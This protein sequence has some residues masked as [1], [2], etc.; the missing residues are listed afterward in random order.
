M[1]AAVASAFAATV[2]EP[3]LASLGGGGYLLVHTPQEDLVH[4]FFVD[5]PGIG[6]RTDAPIPTME[7][8]I[9]GFSGADQAFHAG[10]GSLAV[11]GTLDGLVQAHDRHGQLPLTAVVAPARALAADGFELEP[12]QATVLR[13]LSRILSLTPES[14]Q[15]YLPEDRPPQAG[16]TLANPALAE[17]LDGIGAGEVRRF[18]DLPGVDDL[19]EDVAAAGGALTA[20]DLAN[21]SPIERQSLVV[22]HCGARLVTNPSPALGGRILAV[23][24]Q[25]LNL[26]GPAAQ[27][28][29]G[30]ARVV[31][32]LRVATEREKTALANGIPIATKGTTHVSVA[33]ADGM[34]ASLTQ[35]NGSCSGVM[36]AGTGV[37][38]NNVMGEEDLHPAGLHRMPPARRIPSMMAPSV[39]TLPDGRVVAM[40][41]GGSERIR[42]ALLH[43]IVGLVDR[44]LSPA[45][46]VHQPRVHW[47][48][49]A[50]QAEPGLGDEILARL[51]QG[52]PVTEWTDLDLYF[53]GAHIVVRGPE[54]ATE[55]VG[56]RRRGG[57]SVL[58]ELSGT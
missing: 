45:A 27:D 2:C 55:A 35:S 22:E 24:T 11:P 39:L 37:Q 1:D 52:A 16:E 44:G 9:V 6:R 18:R 28:P 31:A 10:H 57:V 47:D 51:R 23:A 34:L 40:G 15:V 33:D 20:A 26:D 53:G 13:L 17:V 30:V 4:D 25:E 48:G 41:S 58:V 19:L 42:S 21:Y 14:R 56:D 3:G 36:V 54:D 7:R 49:S 5:S 38:I 50:V 12:M 8:V 46:A 29:Q 43:I 32:A